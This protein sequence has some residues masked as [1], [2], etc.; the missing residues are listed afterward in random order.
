VEKQPHSRAVLKEVWKF[1][2]NSFGISKQACP[3]EYKAKNSVV[4]VECTMY[5]PDTKENTIFLKIR[6]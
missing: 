5:T 6:K 4:Y 1:M 2:V 3:G